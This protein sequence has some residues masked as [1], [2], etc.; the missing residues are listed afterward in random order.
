MY[1]E[2]QIKKWYGRPLCS[3]DVMPKILWI[4]NKEPEIYE[5]TSKFLTG[6]SF[7]TAK[8]CGAYAVDR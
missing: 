3:S 4:K 1:G 2:D 8:L 6:S 5:K 7:I